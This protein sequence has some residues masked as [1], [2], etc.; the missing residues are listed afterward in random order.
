M[1]I[2]NI[3]VKMTGIY[4]LVG[5]F[6]AHVVYP[7]KTHLPECTGNFFQNSW[8]QTGIPAIGINPWIAYHVSVHFVLG[9][10]VILLIL[11]DRVKGFIHIV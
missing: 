3:L 7:I 5:E 1:K 2:S 10:A 8:C 11:P 4:G 9:L 6:F